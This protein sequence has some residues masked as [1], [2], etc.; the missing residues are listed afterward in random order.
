MLFH[1]R[2]GEG[3]MQTEPEEPQKGQRRKKSVKEVVES[4]LNSPDLPSA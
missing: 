2:E 3:S 1:T 4:G